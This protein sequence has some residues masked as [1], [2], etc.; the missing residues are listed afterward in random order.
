M[1]DWGPF[2]KYI[3]LIILLVFMRWTWA[4]STAEPSFSMDQQQEIEGQIEQ[5][6]TDRIHT[7]R[8]DVS[9]VYFQQMYTEVVQPRAEIKAHFR[10]RIEGAA[11][12]EKES[13]STDETF[14]GVATLRSNDNGV[15]W[16]FDNQTL[17]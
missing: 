16:V 2:M 15:T 1:T 17:H 9:N 11:P 7:E 10:Y 4:L 13:E 14:E 6:I 3:C 5:I 8:S 12:G